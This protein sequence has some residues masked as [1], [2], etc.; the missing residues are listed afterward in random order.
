M[1]IYTFPDTYKGALKGVFKAI[2]KQRLNFYINT[3]GHLFIN[4][5]SIYFLVFYF[6]LEGKGLLFSKMSLEFYICVAGIYVIY[7]QD[8]GKI[9][10]ES[11]VRREMELKDKK[12]Y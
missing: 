10:E 9:I 4:A 7:L 11:K 12:N 8:W 3:I 5:I 2:A 6:H 1:S